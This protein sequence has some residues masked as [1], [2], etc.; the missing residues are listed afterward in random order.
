MLRKVLL[1]LSV[2]LLLQV[3]SAPE[4]FARGDRLVDT[5]EFK[6]GEV[7]G[8]I[9]DYTGMVEG[10]GLDWV[11]VDPSV[12]LSDYKIRINSVKNISEVSS[13]SIGLTLEE[14]FESAMD[15]RGKGTKGTLT[16]ETAVYWAERASQGKK[17]IPYAGGHLAQAGVGVEV[18][19]RD[20]KGK[21]VAKI[22]HAGRQGEKVDEA[23]E[24]VADDLASY[25]TEH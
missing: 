18:I 9:G 23:A 14:T 10:D 5:D 22:R 15:R 6:Q 7:K 25:F 11:W 20:S 24:E 21:I 4:A 8:I 12:K 13:K 17:W 1:S 3:A 19:L 2:V 16:S